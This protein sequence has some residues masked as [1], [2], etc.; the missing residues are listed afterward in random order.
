V[1][2]QERVRVSFP[3]PFFYPQPLAMLGTR[4][5]FNDHEFPADSSSVSRQNRSSSGT[6][7]R[8]IAWITV[9]HAITIAVA[10]P[11]SDALEV[12]KLGSTIISKISL[13]RNQFPSF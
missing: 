4:N 5:F 7:A 12:F 9:G 11:K 6:R 13:Q 1:G 10:D 3:S 8:Q 2:Y